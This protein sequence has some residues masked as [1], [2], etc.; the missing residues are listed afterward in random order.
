[1][2]FVAHLGNI[3]IYVI[4][5]L[6]CKIGPFPLNKIPKK[7]PLIL[8][9][10]HVNLV[11]G[12]V[13]LN[14][15]ASRDIVIMAKS[16]TWDNPIFG[17]VL[18]G[19]DAISVRRGEADLEAFRKAQKV[20]TDGKILIISPEGTRS[21]LRGLDAGLGTGHAGV[22]L[23][24]ARSGAPIQAVGMFNHRG[25]WSRVYRGFKRVPIDFCAGKPFKLDL[26]GKSL[27]R[28]VRQQATDEIMYELAATL[29]PD[30]RGIYADL[31]KATHEYIHPV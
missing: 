7:G 17:P 30:Y 15:L 14:K 8:I 4:S 28:D 9:F 13:L 10:N 18:D 16:E 29:P 12:P 31:S 26:G 11:E 24:A 21:E 22:T 27:S 5:N 3:A 2:N 23:L 6:A 19:W 1:M 20:L 25:F